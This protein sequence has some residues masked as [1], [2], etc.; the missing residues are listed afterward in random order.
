MAVFIVVARLVVALLGDFVGEHTISIATLTGAL[1][2]LFFHLIT[3]DAWRDGNEADLRLLKTMLLGCSVLGV[4]A[5]VSIAFVLWWY[6]RTPR[7]DL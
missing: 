5:I 7:V 6:G 2:G 1:V 3:T 4:L